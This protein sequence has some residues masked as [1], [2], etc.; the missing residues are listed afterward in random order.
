MEIVRELREIPNL[1]LALGFFDGVHLGHQAVISCAVEFARAVNCKSAVITFKEHPYCY[2]KKES[3]KY[4]LTIEDKYKKLEELGVDYVIEL[5]FGKICHLTPI[6]Y[7][8]EILIKYFSPKAISTGFNHYFGVNKTGNVLFLSDCQDKYNFVYFATPPQSVFG[9]I[10]S[11]TAIRSFIKSGIMDMANSMLGYKFTVEGTVIHGRH[12]A[13]SVLGY[14]TANIIYPL[15]VI[16]IPH[17]VYEVE[18]ELEY[19]TIYRGLANYG[20]SPT[21]TD[22]GITILETHLLNFNGDL[23]N[24]PIKVSFN[25]MIRPEYKFN[26]VDELKLQIGLDVQSLY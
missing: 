14:P 13:A 7:L 26:S 8:E 18:V 22:D 17:G 10:V 20:T 3:P 9:D 1:S 11:S 16:E 15:D 12:V 23:Y 25:R 6:Q 2:F 24:K 19:G 21:L 5:D 4:I